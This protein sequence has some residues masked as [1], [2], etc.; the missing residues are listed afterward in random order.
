MATTTQTLEAGSFK[1]E[2][3]S[4]YGPADYMAARGDARLARILAGNDTLFNASCHLSPSVEMAV[5]V[6]LQTDYA[7]WI[8]M[9]SFVMEAR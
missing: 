3:T 2:G 9:R 5:L 8:G 4:I 1:I 7:G 6:S